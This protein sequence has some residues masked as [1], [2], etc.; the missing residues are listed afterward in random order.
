MAGA[1]RPPPSGTSCGWPFGELHLHR[2][3]AGT[4][5]Q[6]V[7]SQRVL[8]RN[9]FVCFGVA[10]GYLKIAGVWQD[11]AIYQALNPCC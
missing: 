8:K 6:N 7:A 9:G 11:H 4:L 2:I 10:P 5:L 3:E 1:W